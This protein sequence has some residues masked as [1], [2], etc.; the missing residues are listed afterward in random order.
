MPLKDLLFSFDGRIRRRDWWMWGLGI[1]IAWGVVL[2]AVGGVLFGVSFRTSLL[3]GPELPHSWTFTAYSLVTFL[4]MLWVQAAL[5]AKR[6]HDRNHGA[7]ISVGLTALGGL[8]SFAPEVVDLVTNA[9][10]TDSQFNAVYVATNVGIFAIH[11]YLLITQGVLDGTPGP[12]RF[13]PSPKAAEQPAFR[14]PGETA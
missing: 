8:A 1:G 12:N 10:L 14:E 7:R 13:G 3:G 6:A 9:S 2:A 4:P 5:A 11:F